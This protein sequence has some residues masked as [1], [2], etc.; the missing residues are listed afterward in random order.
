MPKKKDKATIEG[1][2]LL[3]QGDVI[4]VMDKSVPV[5]CRVLSCL[6]IEG[7]GCLAGL[8]ILEGERKGER[9]STKLRPCAEAPQE[10]E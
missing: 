1:R 3:A 4:Q 6:A 8:E 5:K 10:K 7:G 9:I 2:Q